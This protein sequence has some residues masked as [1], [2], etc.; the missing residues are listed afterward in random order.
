[1]NC[2]V[3]GKKET[4]AV[5]MRRRKL[6][7]AQSSSSV[8]LERLSKVMEGEEWIID[9]NYSSTMEQRINACDTVIFLDYPLDICLHGVRERRGKVRTDMPWVEK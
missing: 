1:M 2:S 3:C 9:G 4:K 8:F 5:K 6:G 7:C